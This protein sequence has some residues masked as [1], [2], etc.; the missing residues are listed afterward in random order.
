MDF[1]DKEVRTFLRQTLCHG[2]AELLRHYDKGNV[3]SF[4]AKVRDE[5][6]IKAVQFFVTDCAQDVLIRMIGDL[7][8]VMKPYGDLIISGGTA[9]NAYLDANDRIAT[10]DID[11][12]FTPL[13]KYKGKL[14]TSRDTHF[15]GLLQAAKLV[16]W[17]TLGQFALRYRAI[18]A[19]RIKKYI[20]GS[21][22]GKML[23]LSLTPMGLRRRY[24]LIKKSPAKKVLV[25]IELFAMDLQFRY[26]RGTRNIGGL[27]DIAYMRPSE[28]GYE[29][30]YSKI[31]GFYYVNRDTNRVVLDKRVLVASPKFLVED[32]YHLQKF[33]LRPGKLA[34]D[35]RR[36]YH[37]CKKALQ[38]KGIKPTDTL[39][40][41][42]ARAKGHTRSAGTNL[43]ARPQASLQQALRVNPT[44]Y[45]AVTSPPKYDRVLAQ[46]FYGIKG[47]RGL[48]IPGYAPTNSN[49]RFDQEKGTWVRTTSTRYIRNEAN[50]RPVTVKK[51]PNVFLRDTL[52]GYNPAR[53]NWIPET[54]VRKAAMIPMV[55]L[56]KKVP[57][58]Q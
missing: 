49:Q 51:G 23:G 46:F 22:F 7:T 28:F 8:T 1:S 10:S 52:Y 36:L 53:D 37:F 20:L 29:A 40:H 26:F 24:T 45:A 32:V 18:L 16:M 5:D 41:L 39:D 35:R 56:T 17:N 2:D 15:F 44:R 38:L 55:G 6:V 33:H 30:T 13:F 42:Y 11:T 9:F 3:K 43:L 14:V 57:I 4:R 48:N 27:V 21:H 34:L 12:K 58:N 31:P 19:Q 50:Y 25:D 54:L 47:V